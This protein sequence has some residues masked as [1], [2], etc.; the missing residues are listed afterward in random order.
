MAKYRPSKRFVWSMVVFTPLTIAFY[1][2]FLPEL[3]NLEKAPARGEIVFSSKRPEPGKASSRRDSRPPVA[4]AASFSLDWLS[5]QYENLMVWQKN[6]WKRERQ[7]FGSDYFKLLES[8]QPATQAKVKE[9]KRLGDALLQRVL[10]RYPEL[11]VASK[12]VPPERNG[13]LRWLEFAERFNPD[14][15]RVSQGLDVPDDIRKHLSGEL[16]WDAAA[17]RAWLQRERA[18]LD[19]IRSI[20]LMTEQSITGIDIERWG[21]M[22]ARLAKDA[23]DMLLLEARLAAEEGDAARALEAIRAAN[24]LAAHFGEVETPS[25]LAVTVQILLQLQNQSYALKHIMPALPAGQL[26]PVAWQ[27][28]LNPTVAPP[29]EFARIMVGEWHVSGREFLMP[30]LANAGDPKYPSDPDA[31]IDVNAGYFSQYVDLYAS[32][33]PA[34]WSKITPPAAPN[35]SN[36]SR[37]SRDAVEILFVGARA[38]SRGFE[39]A[40]SATGMTQAAFAIMQDQPIPNDPIYGLAYG[41]DPATRTLSPPAGPEF[42]KLQLK[43]IVVPK[44]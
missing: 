10:Q 24:G 12:Q 43:P 11:A 31:L 25:L 38:W 29:S 39:R 23:G 1:A 30:M 44:P 37:A 34:D 19:E 17:V 8:K 2:G 6:P 9:L 7:T 32:N 28:T 40:Q 42:E 35:G 16:P 14:P 27:Q 33:S 5:Q 36:L 13:F 18:N 3:E 26:D 15:K 22:S 41:W 20:G 21:F 4:Q